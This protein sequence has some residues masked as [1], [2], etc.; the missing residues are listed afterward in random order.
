MLEEA[1]KKFSLYDGVHAHVVFIAC[2][3]LYLYVKKH[4]LALSGRSRDDGSCVMRLSFKKKSTDW[5]VLVRM[6]KNVVIYLGDVD[7]VEE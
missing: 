4:F 2:P 1:L 6:L 3:T 7:F 5:L